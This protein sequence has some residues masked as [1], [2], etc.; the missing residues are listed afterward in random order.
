M[1]TG[2]KWL[3]SEFLLL[4][5]GPPAKLGGSPEKGAGGRS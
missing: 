3:A 2:G 5:A 1:S 4:A